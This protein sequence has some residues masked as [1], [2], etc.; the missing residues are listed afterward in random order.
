M[1]LIITFSIT[2][3]TFMISYYSVYDF[4]TAYITFHVKHLIL[5]GDN[6]ML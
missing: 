1:Q 2:H 5:M 3:S 4:T 6:K